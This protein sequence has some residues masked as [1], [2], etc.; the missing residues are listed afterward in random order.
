MQMVAHGLSTGALFMLVGALQ[1][2]LHTRDLSRMGGLWAT[3]PTFSAFFLF[4]GV[5]SLG[6]PG[7]GNFL[8]EFLVLIGSYQHHQWLTVAATAGI[9]LAAIY[10]LAM[11]QQTVHGPAVEKR[12]IVD[13]SGPAWLSL[14]AMAALLVWLGLYPQPLLRRVAPSFEPASAAVL[15]VQQPGHGRLQ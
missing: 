14:T 1:E 9:V 3:I 11:I 15:S 12:S 10:A 8:G 4:F 13:V 7:L 2:R 6:L 5:A